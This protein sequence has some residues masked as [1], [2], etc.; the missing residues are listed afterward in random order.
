[1]MQEIEIPREV[2]VMTLSSAVLFPQAIMPLHI[3]EPRYR[4]ML[5]QVLAKDRIFAVA[6]LD[7]S[8]DTARETETPHTIAGI[9]IVRACRTNPD[10]TSNLLLQGLARVEFE[11]IITESPFR[12]ARI[13]QLFSVPGG[14][15][16]LMDS[17]QPDIISLVQAQ[18]N[19]GAPIPKE[20]IQ[21]LHSIYEAECMLDLAISTLC[22]K[23]Q[24][25]QELLETRGILP[26]YERFRKFLRS[27]IN[28]LKLE[29]DLRGGLDDDAISHN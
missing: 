1:M 2:P 18:I 14:S 5:Q 4:E 3:F 29:R 10:G 20:V 19:L 17:I 11:A 15:L 8:T 22:H 24:L 12:T 25:K 21:F 7:E 6:A 26:R 28:R 27:E 13:R 16:D 23:S 9:G